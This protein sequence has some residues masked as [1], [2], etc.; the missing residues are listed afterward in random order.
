MYISNVFGAEL[1]G[2][3]ALGMTAVGLVSV[4]AGLG[5]DSSLVRFV[6]KYVAEKNDKSESAIASE[7]AAK[8]YNL[9][10]L[11]SNI[12]IQLNILLYLS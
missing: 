11:K 1:L 9:K 7:L 12:E 5:Y 10:I 6:S 8:T 2:V 3:F 4:F